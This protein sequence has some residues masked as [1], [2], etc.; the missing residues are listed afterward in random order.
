[1]TLRKEPKACYGYTITAY[2]GEADNWETELED[3]RGD[4]D[5]LDD[6][7][8]EGKARLEELEKHAREDVEYSLEFYHLFNGCYEP[9][10]SLP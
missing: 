1:M 5:T 7:Q 4:F 6:C 8:L 2:Y 3:R 10:P 9:L